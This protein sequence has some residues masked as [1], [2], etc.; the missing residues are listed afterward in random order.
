MEL[1]IIAFTVR[2]LLSAQSQRHGNRTCFLVKMYRRTQ[3]FNFKKEMILFWILNFGIYEAFLRSMYWR[4]ARGFRV[5]FLQARHRNFKELECWSALPGICPF[6]FCIYQLNQRMGETMN[7]SGSMMLN[8]ICI[9]LSGIEPGLSSPWQYTLLTER[10]W[11][12][13]TSLTW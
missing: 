5:T 6:I 12:L 1:R 3:K 11:F 2:Q 9:I 7:C 10:S 13:E 8:N 4:C